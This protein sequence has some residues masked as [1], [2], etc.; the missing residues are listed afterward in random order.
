MADRSIFCCVCGDSLGVIRDA[1]LRK[2]IAYVC[3]KHK[4]DTNKKENWN[5]DKGYDNPFN[6]LFTNLWD[7]KRG[8]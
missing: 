6:D 3:G 8:K 7:K 4:P 5:P 2:D 1:R